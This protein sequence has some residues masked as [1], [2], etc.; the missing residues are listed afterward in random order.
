M[1]CLRIK[2]NKANELKNTVDKER[3]PSNKSLSIEKCTVL[4]HK[5]TL[6]ILKNNNN[7]YMNAKSS[8]K[9]Y[10]LTL[11]KTMSNGPCSA[12]GRCWS[13]GT[14]IIPLSL[15]QNKLHLN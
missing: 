12:N 15:H 7:K 14:N 5:R 13:M 10:R 8:I 3:H 4:E 11:C 2:L 1:K 6:V 9:I